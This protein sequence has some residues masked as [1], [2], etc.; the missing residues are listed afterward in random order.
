MEGRW[1]IWMYLVMN[2]FISLRGPRTSEAIEYYVAVTRSNYA[3]RMRLS[4]DPTGAVRPLRL[5][6][7]GVNLYQLLH[8]DQFHNSVDPSSTEQY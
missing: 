4:D 5:G 1:V 7:A 8:T 2:Y 3:H 6:A